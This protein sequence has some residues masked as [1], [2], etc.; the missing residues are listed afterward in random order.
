MSAEDTIRRIRSF[1]E[2]RGLPLNTLLVADLRTGAVPHSRIPTGPVALAILL[3]CYKTFCG[4]KALGAISDQSAKPIQGLRNAGFLFASNGGPNY[5]VTEND[6]SGRRILGFEAPVN[7]KV[8]GLT[9]SARQRKQFLAGR[10]DPY[11]GMTRD[12]EIDHRQPVE[13]SARVSQEYPDLTPALAATG[14]ADLYY[15]PLAKSSN[16]AK[17]GAC[18]GC[19]KGEEI[20]VPTVGEEIENITGQRFKRRFE[21][22]HAHNAKTGAPACAGCF[23]FD[24]RL[25]TGQ[26]FRNR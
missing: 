26:D 16:I 17:R 18:H 9:L 6:V 23:F 24:F 20:R 10:R 12:L 25:R 22:N 7:R 1:S 19:L 4:S 3:S 21:D 15:Q 14:E 11:T 8:A 13:A 5:T 2:K